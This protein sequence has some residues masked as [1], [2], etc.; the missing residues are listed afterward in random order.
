L[1]YDTHLENEAQVYQAFPQRLFEHW[2]GYNLVYP[3]HDPTPACATVPQFYGFYTSADDD[4]YEDLSP[5]LL[6]ELCG[7]PV[8]LDK[9]GQDDRHACAALFFY[10]QS[11]GWIQQSVYERN[12]VV[13]PGPLSEH[14]A[15]RSK[16]QPSFRLI[17]FGRA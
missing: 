16:K 13:Q 10:L 17:D 6:I 8:R 12:V 2:S 5:L 11:A 7:R 15:R 1:P 3:M 9:L 14:P 4:K